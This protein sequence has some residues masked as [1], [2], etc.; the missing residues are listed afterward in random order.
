MAFSKLQALL[1]AAERT[2]DRLWDGIGELMSAFS[3]QECR[4]FLT[5][6]AVFQPERIPL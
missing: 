5:H 1:K 6:Q 3:E 4:N 2:V